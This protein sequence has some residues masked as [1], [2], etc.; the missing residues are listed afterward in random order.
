MLHEHRSR[1]ATRALH[2]GLMAGGI[3]VVVVLY[4]GGDAL[5]QRASFTVDPPTSLAWWQINPHLQHLWATTCPGDPDWR[6]GD[7]VGL[8]EAQGLLKRM[9]KRVGSGNVLDTVIPLYPRKKVDSICQDA[10]TGQIAVDDMKT[11]HG[12]RGSI[13]VNLKELVLG[14]SMYDKYE[15]RVL[16]TEAFPNAEFKIDSLQL[17]QPGDT[18]QAEAFGVLHLHGKTTPMA[19]PLRLWKESAGLRVTGKITIPAYDMIEVY[20][21]SKYKLG[22]GVANMIWKYLNMGFDVILKPS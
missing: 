10:V 14:K 16:D 12:T 22:L 1:I 18:T 15:Q 4:A 8:S 19:V 21:Y 20:G 6:P 13:V 3:A 7:G 2:R 17:V 5:A 9:N 11:L